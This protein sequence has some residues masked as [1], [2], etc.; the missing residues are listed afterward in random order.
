MMEGTIVTT[1]DASSL[2][3]SEEIVNHNATLEGGVIVRD[4]EAVKA[5]MSLQLVVPLPEV[6]YNGGGTCVVCHVE[7][8]AVSTQFVPF[9]GLKLLEFM[10]I[11][12][13]SV[14][15]SAFIMHKKVENYDAGGSGCRFLFAWSSIQRS[16]MLKKS[17]Q[18]IAQQ[19]GCDSV[20]ISAPDDGVTI[21]DFLDTCVHMHFG[22][23][24]GPGKSG[25]VLLSVVDHLF[26]LRS[27][28]DEEPD[29]NI[30]KARE[31]AVH[32]CKRRLDKLRWNVLC[33]FLRLCDTMQC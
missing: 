7:F 31:V 20:Y 19:S 30:G 12:C 16:D 24:A 15:P 25:R 3:S 14:L 28:L 1:P 32:K 5:L 26:E 29:D 8:V 4:S 2:S 33:E 6:R 11:R 17:L 18:S 27:R 9:D 13:N 22:G 10:E 23:I 21:S